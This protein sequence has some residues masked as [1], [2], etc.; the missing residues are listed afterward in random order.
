M[1]D[2]DFSLPITGVLTISRQYIVLITSFLCENER[3]LIPLN[4]YQLIIKYT[5]MLWYINLANSAWTAIS[6]MAFIYLLCV[7]NSLLAFSSIFSNAIVFFAIAT[8]SR[9]YNPSNI[10]LCSLTISDFGIGFFVQPLFVVYLLGYR[11]HTKTPLVLLSI[12]FAGT[13]MAAMTSLA[14][15][16][17]MALYFHLRY[18]TVV[19]TKKTVV[20]LFC[21]WLV[22]ALI[23]P[24]LYSVYY[25]AQVVLLSIFAIGLVSVTV[26]CYS[27]IYRITRRHKRQ[28]QAQ[29]K[30]FNVSTIRSGRSLVTMCYIHGFFVV[31]GLPFVIVLLYLINQQHLA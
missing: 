1:F 23:L 4:W 8:T 20:W 30:V 26:A 19:T 25:T 7:V 3:K 15:D 6:P 13:S 21:I 17:C 27:I 2:N 12:Y 24:I 22:V 11:V 18:S 5:L 10:L 9:L 14:L 31:S 28:I 16:R 29:M